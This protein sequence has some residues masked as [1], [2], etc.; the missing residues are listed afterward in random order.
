MKAFFHDYLYSSVKMLVNQ[1]AISIFGVVLAMAAMAANSNT[2]TIVVSVFSII[3]Y[4]FLIYTMT[5]EIGAKDR[6]SV[7]IGKKAYRPHTGVL[8]AL[9]ANIPNFVIAILYSIGYSSMGEKAWAGSMNAVLTTVSALSEGMY[10]GLLTVWTIGEVPVFR[11]WWSYFLI[12]L[13]CLVTAWIAYFAGFKN[14]RLVAEY[15]NKK[16]DQGKKK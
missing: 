5:W 10:R 15:F 13:P 1:L 12:I 3:F 8:I 9:V 16:P 14:F 4:L 6:V 11:F 2:L 7:D